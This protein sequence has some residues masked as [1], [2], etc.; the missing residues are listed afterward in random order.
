MLK[1]RLLSL[2]LAVA[3]IGTMFTG[4]TVF[5]APDGEAQAAAGPTTLTVD[6]SQAETGNN[7]KTIRAAVAKAK[8]LN[9]QSDAERVTINVQ[10]G[11]YEEQVRIDGAKFITLQQTPGT[12]GKVNLSWY[13]CTGYCTSNTDLTGLYDPKIDWSK[14]E[15]WNGYNANDEKFTPYKI[16]QKLD[17][18]TTISYYDTDGVAHKDTPVNSQLK[19]LGGL[20]WSYDK[21]AALIVTQSS[22]DITIKDFNILNSI[23]T[24]V[25]QGQ[26]DGHVTPEEG[27]VLPLRSGDKFGLTICDDTTEP[28]KPSADIDIWDS[29]TKGVNLDKVKAY[30]ANGGTF[31]AGESAWLVK[32]SA[33]NERGHAI[34]TLGDRITFENVT[35][36]GNQDSVWASNGRA[37]FNKCTLIGGTDYI[38]GSASAVFNECKLGFAGFSDYAY[39]NPLT[40]PN[41]DASRK[42]GYLFWNCTVY[43]ENKLG[44]TSNFGGPWGASGQATFVNA[45]I[46]DKGEIGNSAVTIDPKG[47]ARFGAENGLARLYEYGTKNTSG[48]AVDLSNRIKNK[49]VAE[50][51]YGMGTVIDEWQVLEFNPRNYLSAACDTTGKTFTDDWDP[52]GITAQYANVDAAINN[53]KVEIPAGNETEVDLPTAPDNVEYKWESSSPNAVLKDGKLV[54]TRPALGEPAI[55][56]EITLYVRDKSNKLIGDKVT[57]P[58][59]IEPTTDTTNVFAIPVTVNASAS[60]SQDYSYDITISKN[61]ADIKSQSIVM[62]AG[63]NTVEAKIENIPASADGIEYDV[64]ISSSSSDFTITEP[65]DGKTTVKGVTGTDVPLTITAQNQIDATVNLDVAYASTEKNKVY[66]LIDLAKAAGA[67]AENLVNSDIVKVE[68]TLNVTN[69]NT[70]GNSFIDLVHGTPDMTKGCSNGKLENRFVL[71]KLGHW[72]Q[73]DTVDNTQGFSG[74]SNS[75]HQVLNVSGKFDGTTPNKVAVTINYK[76][77][78]VSLDASGSGSGKTATPVTYGSFPANAAKGDL[79]MAIYAGTE[80]FNIQ[81]VKVTYKKIVTGELPETPEG[82]GVYPFNDVDGGNQCDGV[83]GFKFVEGV[84]EGVAGLFADETD[85]TVMASKFTEHY[86]NYVGGTG[87]KATHPTITLEAPAGKYKIYYVGYN[88]EK[89]IQAIVNGKTYT[90]TAG[91]PLAEKPD[92]KNYV[93]KYYTIDIEMTSDNSTITFDSTETWLPDTY[94]VVIVGS[95]EELGKPDAT[96]EPPATEAPATQAPATQAPATQAPA[97]QAPATQAPATQAPATQA[98]AT[99]APATQAPATQAPA[100]QAPATQA[101][102]TQAPATATPVPATAE[103]MEPIANVDFT[104]MTTVPVYSEQ[105]GSGFVSKSDAIMPDAYRREVADTSKITIGDGGASVT[106]SDGT[107]LYNKA[108][109]DYNNGGLIYRYDTGA[110][111][112]YHLEVEVAD[113]ANTWVAPTGMEAGRLTGTSTWDNCGNVPRTVSA[114]WNGNVWSYDFATGEDFIEIEIEPNKLPTKDAAQTVGVKSIKITPLGVNPAGGKPTIH[115]LGDS[116]QKTYSFNETI[117][118]WGQTLYQYFD[119]NKVNVVNYSMG[120]RAMKSNY[121]EGRTDEP[122][123]RGKKGDYVFIH[124]AH[125]DETVST[126]RFVRGASVGSDLQ[127]N[128]D[129]YDRWLDM[130]VKMIKARG[131]TPVLVTA[132]PRTGSGKY[133]ESSTKPN[134][135][136]PDSPGR[137]RAKATSDSEVGLVEL[138]AGAKDYIDKLDANEVY[139]IYNTYEAGETPADGAANGNSGDGT[140]YREAAARQWCRIMLQS[141]YDQSVAGTDTYTDKNIMADLVSYMPVSVQNAAKSGDW[142]DVFP[143]MASDVSAVDVVPGAEKQAQNNYY[144]RPNIE[145]ALQIGALH[146][147]KDNNFKPTQTITVGEFARGMETVFGLPTNTL[148][149]YVL[150][151]DELKEK[152]AQPLEAASIEETAQAADGEFTVTVQ[153]P[154]EGGKVV[155]YNESQHTTATTDITD[156]VTPEQT[157]DNDY[158]TMKAPKTIVKKSDKNAVFK[159]NPDITVNGVEF[160][161]ADDKNG[162]KEVYYTAKASGTITLYMKFD[163]TKAISIENLADGSKVDKYIEGEKADADHRNTAVIGEVVFDVTEG[164]EYK[165]YC[166]GGTG[167]LYGLMYEAGYPQSD[168]SLNVNAGDSVKIAASASSGY[169]FKAI[170]VDGKEA[171]AT[172]EHTIKVEANTT[173]SAVFEKE[174]ETYEQTMIASDAALTREAMGAILYDAYLAAYGK[175]EDGTWNKVPYMDQNGA[176][177]SPDDPNYDPNIKYDGTPYIPQTGWG[178]LTDTDQ[179]DMG[180]YMKVKEAYNLGLMRTEQGIKRGA[181]QNGNQLE[182][183]AEVTRA[184]AAK[185]LVFCYILTQP[186]KNESQLIPDNT[187]KAAA[188]VADIAAPNEQAPSTPYTG[189]S[190]EEL[191][192]PVPATPTPEP[193][194]EPTPV[195]DQPTPTPGTDVTPEP[196]ESSAP[197]ETATPEPG[198]DATPTPGTDVT[199]EPGTDATP[200][201]GTDVTPEPGTDATPTPGTDATPEP[202]TDATPTPGTDATP[203]PTATP[204]PLPDQKFDGAAPEDVIITLPDAAANVSQVTLNGA[205]VPANSYKVENGV[206]T[207]TPEFLST[208][209]NGTNTVIIE[210]DKGNTY[211]VDINVTNTFEPTAAPEPTSEPS[212]EPTKAPLPTHRPSSSYGGT[213]TNSNFSTGGSAA[214]PTPAATAEPGATSEPS[215]TLIPGTGATAAPVQP[216]TQVFEDVPESYWAYGYI[217]DLYNAGIINGE[218]PT[219]F[220][221]ENPITRAEFTK[222]AVMLFGITPGGASTFADVADTDWFAPYVAAGQAAGIV[223]GTSEITFSPDDNITREQIAAIVGRYLNLSSQAAVNYSDAAAIEDYAL[224]YVAA[225]SEQG[226]LT[227]SDGMFNPKDPAT[228]AEAATIM[229]RVKNQ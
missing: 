58:I 56:S 53:V 136:N 42:Y 9:P 88:N 172:R 227:G 130:Y 3:M 109:D 212:S 74:A 205:A 63:K 148:N 7:F 76:D 43:N 22:T 121:N 108:S 165:L 188:T 40:T 45:T 178:L 6:P 224:P 193:T 104:K 164:N 113:A 138:Y 207:F 96:P 153:Q 154:A 48:A 26:I 228:R 69:K 171:A 81:D 135:F 51:G 75:E 37:Y 157:W 117:S 82:E 100:T 50:G 208:L 110:P 217:M 115:I 102:A 18:I 68:Y 152:N 30:I 41:T 72:T 38:Y 149:N 80:E 2:I 61:G 93:L 101:P 116:T 98:P 170:L 118:S 89:N 197:E 192:T 97:T 175:N 67:D 36:K 129:N 122:L 123:I 55:N 169:V 78:T 85:K 47:W 86:K 186:L 158:Y 83:S 19:N 52:M 13:F 54:V 105:S 25:T 220:V 39:G 70:S 146:K 187:N 189:V 144:Y 179:L 84:D 173:V 128:N 141:I 131:M 14:P 10:P 114:A 126:G 225:L 124:S 201:P 218:T 79:K 167:Q 198:T 162:D 202:G 221:P 29:K 57:V 20:G 120:G 159:N 199:P 156:S 174:P 127:A 66:D 145:K 213:G 185:T 163:N 28:K 155:I 203:E 15:T 1:R 71:A 60:V 27:S 112:A 210:D 17:G 106:E 111:G 95:A 34:A 137:M 222:I 4:L 229:S 35:A 133:S 21:M 31:D 24:M 92:D 103:P 62:P 125:N 99:Q 168:T 194:A 87:D 190:E 161:K 59:T 77:K 142:S 166:N 64:S 160:R 214:T 8:E 180:L 196:G 119:A 176:A 132:M 143:E 94:C 177:L 44:G 200:T 215:A 73:L 219:L 49:S 147:D 32:S 16:G 182:P 195:P 90:A 181:I 107:Y 139:Y 209:P 12:E 226:I 223:N 65:A 206:I 216:G 33:Y 91:T 11:N 151:Y 204:E 5:A 134:G 150:T 46:D 184:K 191:P 211:S 23:P 183:K 140:H